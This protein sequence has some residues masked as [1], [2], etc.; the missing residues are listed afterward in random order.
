MREFDPK[1][2]GAHGFH[3]LLS[4]DFTA[5]YVPKKIQKGLLGILYHHKPQDEIGHIVQVA[6]W[7]ASGERQKGGADKESPAQARL[8]SILSRVELQLSAPASKWQYNLGEYDIDSDV[9]YPVGEEED[10]HSEKQISYTEFWKQ[11]REE[12]D[13][14]KIASGSNWET[15]DSEVYYKT[16]LALMKKYFWCVP[17]AT[18]WQSDEDKRIWPD[19]SLFDHLSLTSAIAACL[20]AGDINVSQ[21]QTDD[22][23]PVAILVRGD[24]SGIQNFIYRISRPEAETG[25]IAKR[26]RG[27]SFYLTILVDVVVDWIL[28][29]LDLPPNCALFVGGGRFDLLIS[30]NQQEKLNALHR[31]LEDWLL[32]GFHGELGIQVATCPVLSKDFS[33]MRCAYNELESKLAVLKQQKWSNHIT[34]PDFFQPKTQMWHVCRICQLTP[35]N[36]PATCALCAQ[37]ENIGRYL[38]QA[39]YLA[40]CYGNEVLELDKKQIINFTESPF[41]VRI[42]FVRDQDIKQ[43]LG[44]KGKINIYKLNDTK[45]FVFPGIA[46]GFRFIAN[47]APRAKERLT[48]NG[49]DPIEVGDVLSF[50]WIAELSTGAKRLGV[51]KADVD[52][53][54][55]VMGEGL[56]DELPNG[57]RP[58]ISRIAALSGTLDLFFSGLLNR[59]CSQ[60]YEDWAETSNHELVDKVEGLFYVVYSG[61]DDLFVLGPWDV[62]LKLAARLN[63]KFA[64]FSGNNPN[65]TLSAGYVQVKPRFPIQKFADLVDQAE[66]EAKQSG[67]NQIFAFGQV[68]TW[69]DEESS[70][71]NLCELA[72]DLEKEIKEN[73]FPRGLIADLGR[74][75]RQYYPT[76]GPVNP[77]WTPRLFY[78]LARRLNRNTFDSFGKKL[79]STM[80]GGKIH[81]PVSI[82][83]LIT[84]KE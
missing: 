67:R 47:S 44:T 14:W 21:L 28:Q 70:F 57:L 50:E 7:W 66:K 74:V 60:V 31:Q 58:T 17:S 65:L 38:P 4:D 59:I 18:P 5:Q 46:S 20:A 75:N 53:L 43:F 62:V 12:V 40:Y 27:R 78:T 37:H 32:K 34:N 54:G 49:L 26:L 80:R 23:N 3:A 77:M 2:Y 41:G 8:L 19:V 48:G 71:D 13:G 9:T 33:D 16:L 83:S 36:D 55:L 63:Q 29:E 79:I 68:M 11:F 69:Q 30:L 42:A 35:M 15:Q 6:D 1:E 52:H 56:S 25:H 72:S 76:K 51:L 22:Q 82:V 24:L 73:N 39:A 81:V 84:R 10:N 64:R 45:N 61:G